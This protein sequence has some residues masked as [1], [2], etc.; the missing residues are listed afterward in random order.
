MTKTTIL[1]IRHGETDW[2]VSG[3][4]QGQSDIP[5]NENGI[6]QANLLAKRL[7]S[8]SIS[9]LYC[10]DL[11]RA[12]QTASILGHVLGLQPIADAAWRERNGGDFEGLS[13][14]E[15]SKVATGN[16][17][18]IRDKD[19]APPGGETNAQVAARV[20]KAFDRIVSNHSGEMIAI[21]SHGGAII[22]LLSLVVGLPAGERARI[23]VSRNTGFS[24]IEIGERGAYLVRLNDETHLED[25]Y[26][27]NRE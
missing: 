18:Q 12:A 11:I 7:S 8:R 14:E 17:F 13:A 2:N 21:V 3:R 23:W 22:T 4:W 1:L 15:L 25:E 9:A 6:K 16:P 27:K 20:Q 19:W 5:L 26:H 24:I 10:S